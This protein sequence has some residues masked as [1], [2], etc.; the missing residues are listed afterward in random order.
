M[1]TFS[2]EHLQPNGLCTIFVQDIEPNPTANVV[3]EK[4]FKTCVGFKECKQIVRNEKK[5]VSMYDD[6]TI[7][8]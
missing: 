1:F 3:C 6:D 5:I 4:N 7:E 2:C 8:L